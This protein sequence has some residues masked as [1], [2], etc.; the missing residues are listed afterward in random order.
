MK[1]LFNMMVVASWF[2]MTGCTPD[3]DCQD[4]GCPFGLQCIPASGECAQI[5][6]DCRTTDTCRSGEVCDQSTGVCRS[7]E[8][9][10][11]DGNPCANGLVCDAQSGF[12]VPVFRCSIDGC[13]PA[14][15]CN[16]GT[17]RCV[18]RPCERDSECPESFVCEDQVCT[19]G[20]RPTSAE[21]PS[22]QACLVQTGDTIGR[23]QD[24][25]RLD[26]DCPFGQICREGQDGTNCE[27]EPP[28]ATDQECRS[29]EVC[30]SGRCTQ[31]PCASDE[32]C[33]TGQICETTTGTCIDNTCSED[34]YGERD[35]REANHSF[36]TAFPLAPGDDCPAVSPP[37]CQYSELV[38]CPGRSDWFSV[39]VDSSSIVRVRVEQNRALPDLDVYVYDRQQ[40]LIVQNQQLDP[41]TNVK[42][43]SKTDQKI[44]VEV[45]SAEFE[46]SS[47]SL[48]ISNEF[49][50]DDPFEENDA[51]FQA[52]FV[53]R[54]VDVESEIALRTCGFDEDW[55]QIREIGAD[56]G[57]ALALQPGAPELDVQVQTSDGRIE[58]LDRDGELRLLR[59]GVDG[60]IFLR[61][62]ATL[63]QSGEY[64][65]R[66]EMTSPWSCPETPGANAG[67]MQA[68][69]LPP[70][71]MSQ[72][73]L[74][75]FDEGWESDWYALTVDEG[76]FLSATLMPS[77]GVPA[78]DLSLIEETV[79]G[80]RVVRPGVHIGGAVQL[81]AEVEPTRT[82]WLRVTSS[83]ALDRIASDPVYDIVYSLSP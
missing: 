3:I 82:Y 43:A 55:I 2:V 34:I 27:L 26:T 38:S 5:I 16:P 74:C 41:V 44:F 9:R 10:C 21:C 65:L 28:C 17:D 76:G 12:C 50:Q 62:Q 36:D 59:V 24:R 56:N 58:T 40:N 78:I 70:D 79:T 52:T 29:D 63:G 22:G 33:L 67:S 83:E 7:Q 25:C 23:C 71:T 39:D 31:P 32:D 60:D 73:Y 66:Y 46:E 49:C 68:A 77:A 8:L 11:A 48:T 69:P 19:I 1:F 75:P 4:V 47:Y 42:F 15:V 14:E 64:R 80:F 37:R 45:R 81:V 18:P 51:E 13:S 72:R 61:A 35:D 57:F 30:R 53:P 20:C 54:S 6:D